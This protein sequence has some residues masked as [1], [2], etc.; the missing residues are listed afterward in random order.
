[1][2]KQDG[3]EDILARCV[4][5]IEEEG[6][7]ALDAMCEAHP[8]HAEQLRSHIDTLRDMK[9]VGDQTPA[10]VNTQVT[11][12][13]ERIGPYRI[14]EV[15]GEGGMGTVYLA[16]QTEPVRREVA[17]KVIK[18]GMDTK[19]VLGRF[20]QE[21]QA[22]AVMNHEHIAKV[23][24]AGSTEKGMPYFVMEH[25]D[26]IPITE[27]CDEHR[28]SLK[29]RIQLFQGVCD[30]VQHAHQKGVVHRDLKP[31]N[32][33]VA[34]RDDRAKPKI[35]DFGLARATEK[36]LVDN[37]IYTEQGVLMG[38]PEYMSPEQ[39]LT[40]ASGI[41]TRTDVYSLGVVL[42][43]LLTGEMPLRTRA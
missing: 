29:E 13:P 6:P 42:Y 27:Y 32:I 11:E 18:L 33:L 43:Q 17:I 2:S 16:E 3:F 26:G 8:E 14:L 23:F 12:K 40:D 20:E 41:D 25:V 1:M 19:A 38:T 34:T 31:S 39:A 21:R 35:I 22:L 7:H 9:L 15:L 4:R 10:Q 24:D 5:R 36:Q 28:L 30:G 37:T